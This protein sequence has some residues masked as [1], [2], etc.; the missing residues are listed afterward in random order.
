MKRTITG[1]PSG[2]TMTLGDLREFVASLE[3]LPDE[4]SVRAR[5]T[6]GKQVRSV[7]VEE[8]DPGFRDFRSA[9]SEPDTADATAKLRGRKERRAAET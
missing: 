9:L 1:R 7:T 6:L 5:V 8:D 4:A 2:R 3:A